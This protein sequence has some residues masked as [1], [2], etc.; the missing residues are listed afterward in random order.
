M[1]C[2]IYFAGSIRG[3]RQDVELYLRIVQQLKIYG[4]VFTEH[5]ADPDLEKGRSSSTIDT[6]K[7]L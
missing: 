4:H 3:G 1:T 7:V 5:V 6:V 2:N